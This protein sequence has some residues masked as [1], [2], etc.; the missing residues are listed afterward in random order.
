MNLSVEKKYYYRFLCGVLLI[1][2][3]TGMFLLCWLKFT[4]AHK[5]VG[6]FQDVSSWIIWPVIYVLLYFSTARSLRGFRIGVERMANTIAAQII[7]IL[8]TDVVGA[9]ISM[10]LFSRPQL[11]G[12]L[13]LCFLVLF[14]AQSFVVSLLLTV[15][16]FIHRKIFPPLKVV[17]IYGDYSNNLFQKVDALKNK[18]QIVERVHYREADIEEKLL[19]YDAVL[20]ND[21]PDQERNNFLK[22]CFASDKRVYFV[23]KIS[24]ILVKQSERLNL[25]D[26][27]L[28]LNRNCGITMT[29]I[30]VKRAFDIFLSAFGLLITSP[31]FAITSLAIKLNDGGPVFFKQ[32]RCTINCKKFMIIKFRSMIVDAE[33]DGKPHPAGEKDDRITKVGKIIRALRIDELPQLI[34][35]LKGEMSFIGP[36]PERVEHVEHYTAQIPEFEF[37]SKVKGGLTGYAQVYG[38]YNTT[39]LDKLKLDLIYITNYSLLLDFQIII[40]TIKILFRKES[41]EGFTEERAAEM[42]NSDTPEGKNSENQ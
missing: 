12:Y 1:A 24:D 19:K 26:T 7:S 8:M 17:E 5:L 33:K 3:V 29:E 38:K 32:E 37:R 42:H 30:A 23:P 39:A 16:F 2:A 25:I 27:P 9:L 41:T 14:L 6:H 10:V 31:I 20:I 18:Y 34:N 40:E 22:E 36:R 13:L 35:I 11:F 4:E 28:A 21:I 15:M